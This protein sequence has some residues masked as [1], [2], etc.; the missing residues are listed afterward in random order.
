MKTVDFFPVFGGYGTVNTNLGSWSLARNATTGTVD[1]ATGGFPYI[2]SYNNGSIWKVWRYFL[3]VDTSSIPDNAIITGAKVLMS[4]YSV[5]N[6]DADGNDFVSVIQTTQGDAESLVGADFDNVGTT[7]GSN[8]VDVDDI[9]TWAINEWDLN[10]T[11]I[12][13]INKS[14]ITYLGLR[15]GH[16]LLDHAITANTQVSLRVYQ[17]TDYMPLL[18]VTY[19]V[20][21]SNKIMNIF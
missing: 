17:A 6:T 4:C 11:G 10:D 15:G 8:R 9:S 13:W 3:P 2:E 16:D 12:G 18:R 19:E 21:T 1:A 5:D 14:G 7:E 20:P